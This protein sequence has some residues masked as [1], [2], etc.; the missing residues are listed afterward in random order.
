MDEVVAEIHR[1]RREIAKRRAK[2]TPAEAA[3]DLRNGSNRVVRAIE[4]ERVKLGKQK[5]SR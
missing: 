2:M 4:R 3:V 5:I 1:I